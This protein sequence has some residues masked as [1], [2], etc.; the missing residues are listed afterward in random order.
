MFDSNSRYY[1]LPT[2][3]I[4]LADGRTIV[5]IRRRFIPDASKIVIVAEHIVAQGDRLDNISA[6]YLGDPEQYWRVAD[7]NWVLR[8][9]DLTDSVGR[10]VRIA[11]PEFATQ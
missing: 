9:E 5:Y 8:P 4:T 1:N 3:T 11:Q 7:A 10:R 2:T 6:R